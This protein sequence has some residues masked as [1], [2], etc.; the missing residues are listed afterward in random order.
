MFLQFECLKLDDAMRNEV[1]GRDL[2]SDEEGKDEWDQAEPKIATAPANDHGNWMLKE[3]VG[4]AVGIKDVS[5]FKKTLGVK[6]WAKRVIGDGEKVKLSRAEKDRLY[7][8]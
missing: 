7:I 2:D 4:G 1:R 6:L 3:E 8:N 5:Y